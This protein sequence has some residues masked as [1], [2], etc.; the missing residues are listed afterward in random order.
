[1]SLAC[2]FYIMHLLV[3]TNGNLTEWEETVNSS[4][5]RP[6]L[7]LPYLL[8][9]AFLEQGHELSSIDPT[10]QTIRRYDGVFKAV[11]SSGQAGDALE[12][13][14][15]ALL[16]GSRGVSLAARQSLSRSMPRKVI[17]CSYVWNVGEC[18]SIRAHRA[19][20]LAKVGGR[21]ARAVALMT[22]EQATSAREWLPDKVP[23]L[24][25]R[26]GIDTR[27]YRTKSVFE[28]V[29]E[30]YRRE[31]ESLLRRPY[32]VLP[33][34]ELRFNEQSVEIARRTGLCVVRIS[35]YSGK[36]LERMQTL[37]RSSG[38]GDRYRCYQKI[39]YRF[40]RFLLQNARG[41]IGLVDSSWQPAGWTVAAEALA[42]GLPVVLYEGLVSR[43]LRRLGV[44]ESMLKVIRPGDLA[45][46][47]DH[48]GNRMLVEHT[49][50]YG[51]RTRCFAASN[52]DCEE[53]G[54]AFVRAVGGVIDGCR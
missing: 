12:S 1:M 39:S 5:I 19:G 17:L 28:D 27:F 41:Y 15:G 14:D 3:E 47:A 37:V 35:Q 46:F 33:G 32:V 42:T 29:P 7:P 45:A 26:C 18:L 36:R 44:D 13:A 11:Y 4:L 25:L 40:M 20:L 21:L 2:R 48:V 10:R 51:E 8:G 54:R 30:E 50:E 38:V 34:D 16:W 52:L 53:A 22:E 43:E 23:V 6:R 31:I 24:L 49:C 9:G